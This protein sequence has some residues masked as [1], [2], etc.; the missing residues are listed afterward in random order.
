MRNREEWAEWA[1]NDTP[2]LL[3]V[4]C[5]AAVA[6]WMHGVVIV[7]KGAESTREA[8]RKASGMR[9]K[10]DAFVAGVVVGR[11]DGSSDSG[12]YGQNDYGKYRGYYYCS[13]YYANTPLYDKR[14]M[15]CKSTKASAKAF[16]V[17]TGGGIYRSLV[18]SSRKFLQVLGR[19]MTGAFVPIAVIAVIVLLVYFV[20]QAMRWGII[21]RLPLGLG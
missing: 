1:I 4:G 17:P 11:L 5:A 21:A 15:N 14:D 8:A 7:R 19:I 12:G 10:V 13:D 2:S 16:D 3:A 20:D 18:D 9:D 6:H